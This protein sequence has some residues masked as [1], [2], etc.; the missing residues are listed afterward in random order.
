MFF[1]EFELRPSS[2]RELLVPL[3]TVVRAVLLPPIE[4]FALDAGDPGAVTDAVCGIYSFGI[5]YFWGRVGSSA[6]ELVFL[7]AY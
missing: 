4:V 5:L 3:L 7:S 1:F 6:L 2:N